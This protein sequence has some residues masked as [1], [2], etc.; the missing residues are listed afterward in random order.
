MDIKIIVA[1]HKE[2]WMPEDKVYI[3]LQVGK[4]CPGRTDLGYFGDDTGDNISIKNP[5]YCELTGLYW[6]WKNL[7]A[8][9]IGLTHYRRHFT[10]KGAQNVENKKLNVLKAD[11]WQQVLQTHHVVVPKKRR[12]YI[13][14]IQSQYI[15]AHNIKGLAAAKKV[16]L[17]LHPEYEEAWKT[18]MNRNWGHMFNMFVMRRDYFDA[19]CS[20]LFSILFEVERKRNLARLEPRIYGYISE[21]LLDVW[22]DHNRIDYW[23]QNVSFLE[24]QNWVKKGGSFVKRKL[25]VK[26]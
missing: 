16:L 7:Q 21:R 20:W 18:V 4:A 5:D 17:A 25:G 11:E 10:S 23:E 26:A 19:Y 8:D 24:K 22:I 14:T 15:H 9:Y 12:Y 3:P 6:A 2:Y 1:A 13:E